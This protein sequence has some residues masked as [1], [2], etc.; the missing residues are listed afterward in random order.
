M[1]PREDEPAGTATIL[2][3][4]DLYAGEQFWDALNFIDEQGFCIRL[5]KSPS[6]IPCQNPHFR[7][8]KIRICERGEK[9]PC[10]RRFTGLTGAER[11]VDLY[12]GAGTISLLLA[13]KAARVT[14]IEIVP[15]AIADA[16]RNASL[17]SISNADFYCGAAEDLLPQVADGMTGSVDVVVIDPPRKGLD[18]DCIDTIIKAQ[19]KRIVY[20]SCDSSTLS[21][22]IS[23]FAKGGYR[24]QIVQPVDM[25]PQTVHIET[26]VLMSKVNTVKG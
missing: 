9:R 3:D 17:N 5:E 21:R 24:P 1:A 16:R 22:D 11:V 4:A 15:E 13:R 14:G 23:L 12:C 7:V 19:P 20:V 10:Q 8:F 18:P 25:F 6:I 26:V 2:I